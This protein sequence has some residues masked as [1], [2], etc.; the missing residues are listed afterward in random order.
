[1]NITTEYLS[2][3]LSTQDAIKAKPGFNN[4]PNDVQ[5]AALK[6]LGLHIFDPI[7]E[8][9]GVPPFIHSAFRNEAYNKSIGGALNSQHKFGEA[10]DLDYDNIPKAPNNKALF[11]FVVRNLNFDQIIWEKWTNENPN[12]VHVSCVSVGNRKKVTRFDGKNYI[13]F[14][15][16]KFPQ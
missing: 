12:W 16:Y 6:Y 8:H 5:L 9:F 2:K 7:V 13:P 11:D 15:L 1:M 14:D 10:I 4:F 3:Y